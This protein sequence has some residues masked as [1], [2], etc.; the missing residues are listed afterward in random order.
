MYKTIRT[1]IKPDI[2]IADL[3]FENPYLLLLL[4]HF[5]LDLVMHDKTV[6]QICSE[7]GINEKIFISFANLYNGFSLSGSGSF[8]KEHIEAIIRFLNNSH[9][10]FKHDKYPEIQNYIKKLYEKNPTAEIKMIGKFFD[11]YFTEVTEHLDYEET[12]AFP[13]FHSLLLYKSSNSVDQNNRFSGAEYL[14]HHTDIESKLTDLKN[15]LIRHI[16]LKNDPVNRRK[17]LFSL[18][19]LEFVLNIHSFIEENILIPLVIELEKKQN[20][21]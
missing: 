15:L 14:E 3:I 7:N 13:Y 18:I 4:E 6:S 11:D 17:L 12:V 8:E 20:L 2:R 9:H 19:E 10:Y 5:D 16:S 1:Y 21:V